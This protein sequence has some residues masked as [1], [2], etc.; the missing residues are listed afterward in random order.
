MGLRTLR[1]LELKVRHI[2]G[3][4]KPSISLEFS[5]IFEDRLALLAGVLPGPTS[6]VSWC[7]AGSDNDLGLI[8]SLDALNL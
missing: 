5:Y 6:S 8:G 3:L 2:F 4:E 1:D 7:S